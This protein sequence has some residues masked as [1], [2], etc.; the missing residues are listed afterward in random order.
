[1]ATSPLLAINYHISVSS[2][3]SPPSSIVSAIRRSGDSPVV[4]LPPPPPPPLPPPLLSSSFPVLLPSPPPHSL[5]ADLVL[6]SLKNE[7]NKSIDD[8]GGPPYPFHTTPH[9]HYLLLGSLLAAMIAKALGRCWVVAF[10]RPRP[11]STFLSSSRSLS[12]CHVC[13]LG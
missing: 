10:L 6:L 3:V 13:V 8:P 12:V 9:V 7:E 4:P 2:S 5:L 1:M 11:R